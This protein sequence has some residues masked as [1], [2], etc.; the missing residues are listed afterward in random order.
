MEGVRSYISDPD[1]TGSP[2]IN[3]VLIQPI[4][5][6]ES[7]IPG[8]YIIPT[9][10]SLIE[11]S[12]INI[13][14][15]DIMI[16][17]LDSFD[18][19][20]E[21]LRPHDSNGHILQNMA[22]IS[23]ESRPIS[24]STTFSLSRSGIDGIIK[25]ELDLSLRIG[26]AELLLNLFA[27]IDAEAFMG[28]QLR[29][30]RNPYCWLSTIPSYR[31]SNGKRS[32]AS[33]KRFQFSATDF[34]V[35]AD[36][37]S[38]ST[39]GF[40]ELTS[41]FSILEGIGT[42][43]K[44]FEF[45]LV[46]MKE[47]MEGDD[48]QIQVNHLLSEASRLCKNGDDE[49][50]AIS[51]NE[52][53]FSSLIIQPKFIEEIIFVGLT[54]LQVISVVGSL[55]YPDEALESIDPLFGQTNLMNSGHNILFPL[56][57]FTDLSSDIGSLIE[58][59]LNAL[60]TRL[61][62]IAH[63][64]TN[65][66]TESTLLDNNGVFTV[67]LANVTFSVF[68]LQSFHIYGLDTIT[69]V[70]PITPIESQTLKTGFALKDLKVE[71]NVAI[72]TSSLSRLSETARVLEDKLDNGEST[73]VEYM[74]M[75]LTMH[76]IE[77]NIAMLLGIDENKL[78]SINLGSLLYSQQIMPCILSS[79]TAANITQVLF[80]VGQIDEME[81]SGFLSDDIED[82]LSSSWE[83]L[84]SKYGMDMIKTIPSLI[85]SVMPDF[86]NSMINEYLLDE[87]NVECPAYDSEGKA[88]LIDFR[89]LFYNST[90]A[91]ALGGS[92]NEPYGDLASTLMEGVRSY[93]SDPDETGSPNINKAII[94][95][96]TMSQ[97]QVPGSLYY[98]GKLF[99]SS[100]NVNE[101]GATSVNDVLMFSLSDIRVENLNSFGY[102][103]NILVPDPTF[104]HIVDN[105]ATLGVDTTPL[106]FSFRVMFSVQGDSSNIFNNFD[107]NVELFV[108]TILVSL[109]AQVD[110]DMFSSISLSKVKRL[111]C[112]LSTIS[113]PDLNEFGVRSPG[114]N[115]TA[116]VTRLDF[117][118]DRLHSS[119][120][121]ISCTGPAF[122]K[123][124]LMLSSDN[125]KSNSTKL[126]NS[127]LNI[128]K[129]FLLSEMF[130]AEVDRVL[131]ESVK[132]CPLVGIVDESDT[133]YMSFEIPQVTS[134]S[135]QITIA[136]GSVVFIVAV[137]LMLSSYCTRKN[138]LTQHKIFLSNL[139][140]L[141][142]NRL[143]KEQKNI[144]ERERKLS[145]VTT[146]M[147]LSPEIPMI[148]RF[149]MPIII[150][151]NIA[152]FLSGHLSL[153]ATLK[154]DFQLAG[155]KLIIQDFFEFSIASSIADMWR[156][157]LYSLAVIIFSCSVLWPYTKQIIILVLWV[158][159]PS[160][161]AVNRRTSIFLKLD[162]LGKWSMTDIYALVMVL[163]VFRL[164]ITSVKGSA[165]LPEDFYSMEGSYH[166]LMYFIFLCIVGRFVL[167]FI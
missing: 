33:I 23:T 87:K 5:E 68:T 153:G 58:L 102:P 125:G 9:N 84:I 43:R 41:I 121:C 44:I 4:T 92:G 46:L 27:Q 89:D 30:I 149:T 81:V 3:T 108:P 53:A 77:A 59:G 145:Q 52:N 7:T 49:Y 31:T 144:N 19:P 8:T 104:S 61:K 111:N 134:N 119:I 71:L 73:E 113:L 69:K 10:D 51:F 12:Y 80:T 103:I 88:K 66:L 26:K 162:S 21:L 154:L 141:E 62:N 20:M 117:F 78:G 39:T 116:G 17:N 86:V 64:E 157:K 85:G 37:K 50:Q 98:P 140:R 165:L 142:I 74:K 13:D 45:V 99:E 83:S 25:D 124:A 126:A 90:I 96:Y 135:L 159:P 123:L 11:S 67:E 16:E 15:A 65:M 57:D 97:S 163:V 130:Q 76:D 161:I 151:L 70:E 47:F 107:V 29:N 166:A 139:T 101:L 137:T 1:E 55:S 148:I 122:E 147:I 127:L 129:D 150:L 167:H 115:A 34:S 136:L 160:L 93:I 35:E 32:N 56:V 18:Y 24:I 94:E 100:F 132:Q 48:I 156:I 105:A 63:E 6:N 110:I 82:T 79:I 114:Q 75:S 28:Q 112:W 158:I 146:S 54:L 42:I 22:T 36:C 133:E 40:E 152:L 38:C 138:V 120:N 118:V 143:F 2:N 128:T 14:S 164:S 109:L 131:V 106:K 155:E 72:N 60:N 91:A 95:P